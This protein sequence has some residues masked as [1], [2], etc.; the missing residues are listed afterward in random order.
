[1]VLV[2]IFF[3]LTIITT[4]VIYIKSIKPTKR[5][6]FNSFSTLLQTLFVF[7]TLF[8]TIYI[9]NSSSS[10]TQKLFNN[11]RIFNS[12]FTKIESSLEDVSIKLKEMPKQIELFS[13]SIDSLNE[14]VNVQNRDFKINTQKLN[15]T[16]NSLSNSVKDY[17]KNIHSYSSQLESIV[18]LTNQQLDIWKEQQKVLLNE[19]SRRP[20]LK[21]EAKEISIKNDTSFVNDLVLTNN[22]N[23]ES[24][25]SVIFL[26]I[27]SE[28]ILFVDSEFFEKIKTRDNLV[29][30]SF[31]PS[32]TNVAV[33]SAGA[34]IILSCRLKLLTKKWKTISIGYQIEYYSKYDSGSKIDNIKI[35]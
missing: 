11:L 2:T 23:I 13:K 8:I 31:N 19:L 33:I 6:E 26:K 22:G 1:M 14:V 30:Y 20:I 4:L 9:I 16:I 17:E 10:D 7:I 28:I 21:L 3:S 15:S 18:K 24:S 12:Q 35:K 32:G 25:I 5:L 34:P 27:P 29:I